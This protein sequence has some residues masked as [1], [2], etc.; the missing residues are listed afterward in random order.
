MNFV[1][2]LERLDEEEL[3]EWKG[4]LRNEYADFE[5]FKR[6][7]EVYNNHK[8]LGFETPEE[9]WKANP[10]VSGSTDPSDYKKVD[11]AYRMS[12]KAKDKIEKSEKLYAIGDELR[13]RGQQGTPREEL[14][15]FVRSRGLA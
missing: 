15:E 13:K 10:I 3:N 6:Y 9:A 2:Y 5:E 7:C 14:F 1:N 4:K 11:E 8:R 12:K